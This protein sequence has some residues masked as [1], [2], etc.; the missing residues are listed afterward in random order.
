MQLLSVIPLSFFQ[1][2]NTE[3][4]LD[5]FLDHL[6]NLPVSP[7]I[8]TDKNNHNFI[9]PSYVEQTL[10]KTNAPVALVDTC[11]RFLI[12]PETLTNLDCDIALFT[13]RRTPLG[14]KEYLDPSFILFKPTQKTLAFLKNWGQKTAKSKVKDLLGDFCSLLKTEALHMQILPLNPLL[15]KEA[16]NDSPFFLRW[17]LKV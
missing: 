2:Q 10:E 4:Y 11:L 9:D 1:T 5:C 17:F 13:N 7:L 16:V 14:S 3:E 8:P 12:K 15:K 6:K